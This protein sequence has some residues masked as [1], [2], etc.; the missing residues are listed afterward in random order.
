MTTVSIP[1]SG[2][3]EEKQGM[4]QRALTG[5]SVAHLTEQRLRSDERLF[6]GFGAN[7]R[8]TRACDH[9]ARKSEA[10]DG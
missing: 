9:H 5:C 7:A 1:I 3:R 6:F 8:E 4:P 10:S 2:A